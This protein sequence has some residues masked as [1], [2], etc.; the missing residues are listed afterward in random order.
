MKIKR[1]KIL[2][3]FI[4]CFE[5]YAK[6]SSAADEKQKKEVLSVLN[7]SFLRSLVREANSLFNFFNGGNVKKSF[8][9]SVFNFHE[10]L[11]QFLSTKY[12]FI[13]QN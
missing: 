3:E 7:G 11:S 1:K 4:S 13:L 8:G 6:Y 2:E 10:L 9:N 12:I 5:S